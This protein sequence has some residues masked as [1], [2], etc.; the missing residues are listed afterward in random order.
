MHK[1]TA[2]ATGLLLG[3]AASAFA[4]QGSDAGMAQQDGSGHRF[5]TE[6]R[7]AFHRVG[8]ETRHLLRRAGDSLHRA[9]HHGSGVTSSS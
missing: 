9:G 8:A 5:A 7:G 4:A 3:C 2:L 1:I 6:L